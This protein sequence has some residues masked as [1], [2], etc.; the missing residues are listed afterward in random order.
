M[1]RSNAWPVDTATVITVVLCGLTWLTCILPL[2]LAPV[3]VV[4]GG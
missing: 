4:A 1:A 2:A 3:P